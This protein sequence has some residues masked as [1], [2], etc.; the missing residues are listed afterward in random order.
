M[1][2][3]YMRSKNFYD[4]S[5]LPLPWG[6]RDFPIAFKA[7]E[8]TWTPRTQSR[9]GRAPHYDYFFWEIFNS[10]RRPGWFRQETMTDFVPQVFYQ[11]F[12]KTDP[13]QSQFDLST[14]QGDEMLVAAQRLVIW[15]GPTLLKFCERNGTDFKQEIWTTPSDNHSGILA[16]TTIGYAIPA[17][18]LA[19]EIDIVHFDSEPV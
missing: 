17:Y 7:G 10:G 5:P 4:M 18:I 19:K 12:A 3:D 13:G 16:N 15:H 14:E 9:Q 6:G 1:V 8:K 2:A 11:A